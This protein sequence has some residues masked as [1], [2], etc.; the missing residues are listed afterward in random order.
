MRRV[1][2]TWWVF[3]LL[4]G[5]CIGRPHHVVFLVVTTVAAA[6]SAGLEWYSDRLSTRIADTMWLLAN[7][8]ERS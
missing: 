1:R 4:L 2:Y 3:G 5:Q 7:E 8:D 6:V